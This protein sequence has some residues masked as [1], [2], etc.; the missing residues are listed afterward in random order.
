MGRVWFWLGFIGEF[1]GFRV[2]VIG[3]GWGVNFGYFWFWYVGR[4]VLGVS[5]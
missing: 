3:V 4:E 5:G 2:R 1:W